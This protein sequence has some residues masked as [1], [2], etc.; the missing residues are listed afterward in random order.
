MYDAQ[1]ISLLHEMLMYLWNRA[2]ARAR[3]YFME[4][5][6]AYIKHIYECECT[7]NLKLVE[8]Q[9][10]EEATVK[11]LVKLRENS[12]SLVL[13]SV[14]MMTLLSCTHTYPHP[15]KC[16]YFCIVTCLYTCTRCNLSRNGNIHFYIFFLYAHII[17]Q[18]L[19]TLILT[20]F[21]THA[22]SH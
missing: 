19:L 3:L 20:H 4:K 7:I 1:T 15:Y 21:C 5:A 6:N 16:T 14:W 12:F 18:D 13:L 2:H 11:S 8:L 17:H 22:H 10:R 9:F